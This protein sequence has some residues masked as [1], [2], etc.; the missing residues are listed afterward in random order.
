M[1]L[2]GEK[3]CGA[4]K[5]SDSMLLGGARNK[6]CPPGEN[7][8]LHRFVGPWATSAARESIN[9]EKSRFFPAQLCAARHSGRFRLEHGA[10]GRE[11]YIAKLTV[12]GKP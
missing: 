11:N 1:P 5:I 7:R 2:G 10:Y 4:G 6:C 9:R 12:D 8:G 3:K